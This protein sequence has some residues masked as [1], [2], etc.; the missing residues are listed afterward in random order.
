MLCAALMDLCYVLVERA[1]FVCCA[2]RVF[3]RVEYMRWRYV[4]PLRVGCLRLFHVLRLLLCECCVLASCAS[5][6][7][8]CFMC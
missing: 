3:L 2:C 1:V 4:L 5:F 7:C 8:C 6:V